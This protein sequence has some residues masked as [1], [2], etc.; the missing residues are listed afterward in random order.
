MQPSFWRHF[1]WR[2]AFVCALAVVP[3]SV[4]V[5]AFGFPSRS[6]FTEVCW[7]VSL[8]PQSVSVSA[9]VS[10]AD[11]VLARL[12]QRERKE[13]DP[14]VRDDIRIAWITVLYAARGESQPH[15]AASYQVLGL[16]PDKVW[17]AIVARRKT[18]LGRYYEEFFGEEL[19]PKKPAAREAIA[20]IRLAAKSAAA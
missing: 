18:Q 11:R 6:K 20:R 4:I 8:R 14:W 9:P 2:F 13:I 15:V 5:T 3:C 7:P 1:V 16:H 10:F 19:P 17:P 12:E